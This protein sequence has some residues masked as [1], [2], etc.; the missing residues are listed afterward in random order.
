MNKSLSL[1]FFRMNDHWRF[2]KINW[3][4]SNI[5]YELTLVFGGKD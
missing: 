4:C 2:R 1:S 5:I 3:E